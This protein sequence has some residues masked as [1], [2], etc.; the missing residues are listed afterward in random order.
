[1]NLKYITKIYITGHRRIVGSVVWRVLESKGYSNL[2]G[3]A[4]KIL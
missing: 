4:S 1:M 2:I 3:I